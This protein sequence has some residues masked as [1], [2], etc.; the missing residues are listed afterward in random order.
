MQS[1]D[2]NRGSQNSAVYRQDALL[3][4]RAQRRFRRFRSKNFHAKNSVVVI[5]QLR[6]ELTK[7]LQI[8]SKTNT[9][10]FMK[11]ANELTKRFWITCRKLQESSLF[12]YRKRMYSIISVK[13]YW[14]TTKSTRNVASRRQ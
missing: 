9:S 7:L 5:D 4:E 12:G 2:R 14:N 6:E 10:A 3:G 1:Y 11:F 8:L 13:I